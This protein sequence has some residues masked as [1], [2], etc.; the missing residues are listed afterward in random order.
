LNHQSEHPNAP[1]IDYCRRF[2]RTREEMIALCRK[3]DFPVPTDSKD[4][5]SAGSP[6]LQ[7]HPVGTI[8]VVD[9][10]VAKPYQEPLP[11]ELP[12]SRETYISLVEKLRTLTP[13]DKAKYA[14]LGP[15][16]GV[17]RLREDRLTEWSKYAE[18]LKEQIQR[19]TSQ[20]D[21]AE[22][23]ASRLKSKL[24]AADEELRKRA[25]TLVERRDCILTLDKSLKAAAEQDDRRAARIQEL[26]SEVEQARVF[27]QK[28]LETIYGPSAMKIVK[29]AADEYENNPMMKI[30]FP[31]VQHMAAAARRLLIDVPGHVS[32]Y[33][34]VINRLENVEG[35]LVLELDKT[36]ALVA[37]AKLVEQFRIW[38]VVEY[39]RI[40]MGGKPEFPYNMDLETQALYFLVFDE[41]HPRLLSDPEIR[42]LIRRF[43]PEIEIEATR[44]QL[45]DLRQRL[46]SLIEEEHS[47]TPGRETGTAA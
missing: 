38:M 36:D 45:K 41:V 21:E 8:R 3:L 17:L 4:V 6:T 18:G 32:R 12:L 28:E 2:G 37:R 13:E 42:D 26:E 24:G 35:R 34:A 10:D 29:E 9:L 22:G 19:L 14:G 25:A 5:Q 30:Y 15:L 20:R 40:A 43:A 7:K 16:E 27:R 11:T 33:A 31:S 23:R 44:L 46:G 1:I 39:R 47:L